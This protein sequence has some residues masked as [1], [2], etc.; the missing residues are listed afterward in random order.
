MSAPT[1]R[2]DTLLEGFGIQSDQGELAF[3]GVNLVEAVDEA[4]A[5][6][7]IVVDTGHVGRHALLREALE[8]RG[9]SGS[10]ID[11]VVLTHAHWDH[12]QNLR[13]F[14]GATVVVHPDELRYLDAPHRNDH[15]TPRWTKAILDGLELR[16][17]TEGAELVPGVQVV[18][19][20]GHSP[21][22]IALAVRT[23]EGTAVVAGDA[24]QNSRVAQERRNALV[25]WNERQ[26]NQSVAKLVE[27]A[28][29]V[30]PGHDQAFRLS[31]S[32]AVEYIQRF[33][34]TLLNAAE[35]MEGLSFDPVPDF[36]P[37]IMP[38]I[39]EQGSP[40]APRH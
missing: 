9:L 30:Y 32:G 37:K 23:Q 18:E 31:R 39:E 11:M 36:R 15:A 28:D 19:A 20:P 27:L 5:L 3:C 33:H 26:A 34:L 4:G 12:I 24:I 17:A 22:T 40:G 29:V 21:G 7:R 14:E 6:R 16:Q 35:G 25:F 38:G 8:R 2:V 10:D 1:P 13:L